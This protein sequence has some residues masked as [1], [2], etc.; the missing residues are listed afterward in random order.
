MSADVVL[1][2][3]CIG[4]H[5]PG[6]CQVEPFLFEQPPLTRDEVESIADVIR[7]HQFDDRALIPE[8]HSIGFA[9]LCRLG[10]AG[11]REAS[12]AVRLMLQRAMFG[13]PLADMARG[14]RV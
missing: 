7:D 11:D 10:V 12:Q 3:G 4:F 6:G 1:F 8:L 2:C 13:G 5:T 9:A 14:E